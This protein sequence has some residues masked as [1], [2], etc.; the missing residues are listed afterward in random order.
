MAN[1]QSAGHGGAR[2]E[3][4]GRPT[5]GELARVLMRR[6]AALSMRVAAVFLVLILG[7]PLVNAY[8][9]A[10]GQQ[11]VLGFPAGWFLL[12][13]LF[14]PI[15]WA[16]STYFVKASERLEAEEAAMIRSERDGGRG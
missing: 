4:E 3:T 14:Y 11:P 5:D 6:Q 1:K 12:G 7:V 2:P 16:L 8:L 13:I 10:W 9:P 15:T